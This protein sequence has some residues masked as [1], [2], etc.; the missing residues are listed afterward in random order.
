MQPE[1]FNAIVVYINKHKDRYSIYKNTYGAVEVIPKGSAMK[2]IG[3]QLNASGGN[4][5]VTINDKGTALISGFS[6]AI[7]TSVL[8]AENVTPIDIMLTT[9][10]SDRYAVI[11]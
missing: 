2:R 8:K 1:I 4:S 7:M 6:P 11:V 3:W 5:P 10:N 9:V